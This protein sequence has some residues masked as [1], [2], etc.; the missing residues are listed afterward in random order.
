[1]SPA[2]HRARSGAEAMWARRVPRE[3][4][5]ILALGVV[6]GAYVLLAWVWGPMR[7]AREE[8]L[9]S[10]ARSEAALPL[11]R[12]APAGLPASG[13]QGGDEPV[14]SILTDTA[15]ERGIEISRIEPDAQGARLTVDRV[16]FAEILRWIETLETDYGLRVTAAEMSRRPEPGTVRATL[17]V[18]R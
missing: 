2:L 5:L 15:P 9:A 6:L 4:W 13:I 17:M 3:R 16:E 14:A 12:A 7:V 11:L 8:A 10:I 1:M 18:V